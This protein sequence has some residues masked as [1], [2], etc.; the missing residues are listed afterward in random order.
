MATITQI[1]LGLKTNLDKLTGWQVS[2]YALANPTPP[3]IQILPGEVIYDQAM[4]RGLDQVTMLVQAFVQLAADIASQTRLDQ[5]LDPTGPNSL[6]TT[7]EADPTLGGTVDDTSVTDAT[8]YQVAQGANGPVL[9]CGW[10]VQ[11]LAH[12]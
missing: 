12:N 5:L 3:A 7:V 4:H 10:S 6:K 8:G 1:R 9:V 2:A 11:V